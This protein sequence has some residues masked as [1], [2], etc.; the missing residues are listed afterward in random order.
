MYTGIKYRRNIQKCIQ[1][2]NRNALKTKPAAKSDQ[3]VAPS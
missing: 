1:T 3:N 2:F